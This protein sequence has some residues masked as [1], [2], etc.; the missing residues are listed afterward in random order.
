MTCN[1]I[2]GMAGSGKT[3][4][5][6]QIVQ[7][8]KA[9]VINLDPAVQTLP[10]QPNIDIR[11]AINYQQLQQTHQLGPNGAI[12]TAL[13]LYAARAPQLITLC[14]N[15]IS[16]GYE[17]IVVDAP[18]QIEV[19]AWSASGEIIISLFR[20][21][22]PTAVIYLGDGKRA[23]LP[24]NF[25]SGMLYFLSIK[26][27]LQLEGQ[28]LICYNKIDLLEKQDLA[29]LQSYYQD[30]I[31]LYDAFDDSNLMDQND[32][33]SPFL[34]QI[35]TNLDEYWLN[36]QF[37][38]ISCLSGEG[39]ADMMDKCKNIQ[40]ISQKNMDDLKQQVGLE[41]FNQ[42]KESFATLKIDL[43]EEHQQEIE[44]Q[45]NLDGVD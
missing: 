31:A 8:E 39:Y 4:L 3:T 26:Q 29:R 34:E 20:E 23:A 17:Q 32:F 30:S 28:M 2:I 38:T 22:F 10:Y 18:G 45:D 13:S 35:V 6:S 27:R 15:A 11:D 42:I 5:V 25:V 21:T 33:S 44:D 36:E 37:C 40:T 1:I 43:N 16:E 19:F 14:K 41:K 24:N 9:Y 12:L 7:R